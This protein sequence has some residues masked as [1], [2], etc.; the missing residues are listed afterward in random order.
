METGGPN[1]IEHIISQIIEQFSTE[2][3][4]FCASTKKSRKKKKSEG[5]FLVLYAIYLKSTS[6]FFIRIAFWWDDFCAD[7]R[8]AKTRGVCC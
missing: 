3:E 2:D 7:S 5:K 8:K 1:D 4:G 6:P